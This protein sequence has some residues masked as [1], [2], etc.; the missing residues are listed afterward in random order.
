MGGVHRTPRHHQHNCPCLVD[1]PHDG[2]RI[3]SARLDVAWRDPTLEALPLETVDNGISD[4]RILRRIAD[5]QP[6]VHCRLIGGVFSHWEDS[7]CA[8]TPCSADLP[9]ANSN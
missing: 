5:E 8:R 7:F 3:L 6:A 4:R 2:I 9:S 1:G